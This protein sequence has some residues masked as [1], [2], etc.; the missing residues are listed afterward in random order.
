MP[1]ADR[2]SFVLL[3][4]A[5]LAEFIAL[6]IF[7]AA[8]PLFVGDELGGSRA[9]V[10]LA[11]SSFSVS[12]VLLRPSVGRGLDRV[13]RRR[14]LIAAP[15]ILITSA[16]GLA[17]ATSVAAVVVLRLLQGVA[18]AA[19]Y[20]AAATVA[21]D[22]APLDLRATYIARFSLFLYGGFA[23]GPSIAEVLVRQGFRWA[24]AAAAGFAAL[25]AALAF[26][27]PETRPERVGDGGPRKRRFFHPAAVAPGLVLLT[28]AVGYSTVTAFS[29]LFAREI[30]M[31]SG[32][33]YLA[34]AGTILGVRLLGGGLADRFGRARVALPGL[35]S[36][37]LGLAL[38]ALV[39]PPLVAVIGVSFFGAGFAL[40][41]PALMAMAVDRVGE[42]ERGEVLGSFTAFFDLGAS[43]GALV[44]GVI[45]DR[46]GF[47]GAFATP[48]VL[49][50]V[51]MV[52]LVLT[53]RRQIG[54]GAVD[55]PPLPEPAGA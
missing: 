7:L 45:A 50:L 6:G 20:T 2:R 12:A 43:S 27:L 8:L 53:V 42:D 23:V 48:A 18:G 26:A 22:L 10:G 34:F 32:V 51:G 1:P 25:A 55:G 37:A 54:L 38:M 52:L 4:A 41:F 5:T 30:E 49:C 17:V 11:L 21:T 9:A 46:A 3:C 14:F 16:A 35:A 28:A 29:P 15:L 31:S 33:L 44:V 36:S 24:W 19:F 39:P 40:I 47:G 13:G